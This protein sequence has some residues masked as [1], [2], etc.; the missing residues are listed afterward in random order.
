MRCLSIQ[1]T[2][3]DTISGAGMLHIYSFLKLKGILLFL[4]FLNQHILISFSKTLLYGYTGISCIH[5]LL[6]FVKTGI[7]SFSSSSTL[8]S[9][10][11]L[12]RV[13]ELEKV[14]IDKLP[15]ELV[16]LFNVKYLNLRGTS[17][18]ELPKSIGQLCNLQFLDI[19]DTK[20]ERL[21]R[22]IAKSQEKVPLW[23]LSLYSLTYLSL[24]WSRLATLHQ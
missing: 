24:H 19:K 7:F 15:G 8:P 13:L 16:Y 10:F 20:I 12:L 5:S 9:G 22:R 14:A 21:P 18:K 17:I 4:S 1:S 11:K 6:V 3:G 2:E 23:L